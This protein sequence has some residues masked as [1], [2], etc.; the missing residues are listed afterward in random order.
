[1]RLAKAIVDLGQEIVGIEVLGMDR[2]G[3][4]TDLLSLPPLAKVEATGRRDIVRTKID[5]LPLPL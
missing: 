4:L 1:M 5:L 3:I 2:E